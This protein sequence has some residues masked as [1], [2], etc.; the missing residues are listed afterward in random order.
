MVSPVNEQEK[1]VSQLQAEIE[2]LGQLKDSNGWK[3]IV[4]AL[5][6]SIW[7]ATASL[8]DQANLDKTQIDYVR[9][10]IRAARDLMTMPDI[11]EQSLKTEL[12]IRNAKHLDSAK[13][14]E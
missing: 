11:V 9:G 13:A 2:S 7:N 5:K 8:T 1:T 6:D 12:Q 10:A 3:L 4:T 14:E